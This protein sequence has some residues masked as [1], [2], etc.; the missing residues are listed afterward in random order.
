MHLKDGTVIECKIIDDLDD[1]IKLIL[2]ALFLLYFKDE[3]VSIDMDMPVNGKVLH[4]V[5]LLAV[6]LTKQ[7]LCGVWNFRKGSMWRRSRLSQAAQD[8]PRNAQSRYNLPER[9]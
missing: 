9:I 1:R 7:S 8:D 5:K 2:T 4:C 3:I 6:F